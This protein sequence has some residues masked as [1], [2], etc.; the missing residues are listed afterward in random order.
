VGKESFRPLNRSSAA[1][2]STDLAEMMIPDKLLN[3]DHFF[4]STSGDG[5]QPIVRSVQIQSSCRVHYITCLSQ[6]RIG[7]DL[8]MFWLGCIVCALAESHRNTNKSRD[9]SIGI[10][11]KMGRHGKETGI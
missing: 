1:S 10:L 3:Q 4:M 2:E 9:F 8:G 5:F 11:E 7:G 6:S